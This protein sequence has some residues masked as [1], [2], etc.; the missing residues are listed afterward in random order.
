V[1]TIVK[2]RGHHYKINQEIPTNIFFQDHLVC[3][4]SVLVF[5]NVF[6][7]KAQG[8][9]TIDEIAFR[10]V[11]IDKFSIGFVENVSLPPVDTD[12]HIK[13]EGFELKSMN[14]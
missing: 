6:T 14:W 11:K 3:L 7:S 10:G 12:Y 4:G 2:L 13:K 1:Q 9:L 8:K 5:S